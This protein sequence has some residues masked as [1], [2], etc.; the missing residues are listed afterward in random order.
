MCLFWWFCTSGISWIQRRRRDGRNTSRKQ[1][2]STKSGKVD[3]SAECKL[4]RQKSQVLSNIEQRSIPGTHRRCGRACQ[5]QCRYVHRSQTNQ[6]YEHSDYKQNTTNT[7]NNKSYN[8]ILKL[9]FP[10]N[11]FLKTSCIIIIHLFIHS[12]LF[13]I[14]LYTN[15]SIREATNNTG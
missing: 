4:I 15:Y 9:L 6:V 3:M 14:K 5:T 8:W 12:I 1:E 7:D 10:K 2:N 13:I 11:Q